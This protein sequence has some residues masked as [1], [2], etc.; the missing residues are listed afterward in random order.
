MVFS[1]GYGSCVGGS[2][3]IGGAGDFKWLWELCWRD[4][5]YCS[6]WCDPMFMGNLLVGCSYWWGCGDQIFRG[7]VF[8]GV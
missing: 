8:V 2:V 3:A 6:G 5:S 4:C 7:A 1:N